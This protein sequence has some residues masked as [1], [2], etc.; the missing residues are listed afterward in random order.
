MKCSAPAANKSG[1]FRRLLR[2]VRAVHSNVLSLHL[3][4]LH[5]KLLQQPI[6]MDAATAQKNWELENSITTV[7]PTLD[8]IYYYD[9]AQDRENVAQKPW[10][11][12]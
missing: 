1:E 3:T 9:V 12:E 8:Q 7:D 5:T 6:N 10:K 4:F 2:P 11:A